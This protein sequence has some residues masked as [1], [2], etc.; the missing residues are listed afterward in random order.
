MSQ[1]LIFV[2]GPS[3]AGKDSVM[4]WA[5]H[6]LAANQAIVFSRRKVTR[7]P[8]PGSDHDEITGSEFE[9]QSTRGELAW[10]WQAHGFNY[11]IDVTYARQVAA[12]K[13][14]VVNGSREH[15]R[16]LERNEP[17]RIVQVEVSSEQLQARLSNRGREAGQ[18]IAERLERNQLFTDLPFHHRIVNDGELAAA[19]KALA[20]Y[21]EAV[22]TTPSNK[23]E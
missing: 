12:G 9:M 5:E 3:G 17:I 2:M 14:V 8:F 16:Q 15:T 4:R 6:H 7:P 1:R 22:S 18:K 13:I 11:G 23:A 10:Q 19:G 20:D 21:L